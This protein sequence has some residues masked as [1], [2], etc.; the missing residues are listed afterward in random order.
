[1]GSTVILL[2]PPGMGS[3]RA[4]LQPGALVR[5]GQSIGQLDAG[6]GQ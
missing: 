4:D 2:M 3:W 1:M 6:R 5:V